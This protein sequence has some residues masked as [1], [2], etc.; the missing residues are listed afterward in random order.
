MCELMQEWADMSPEERREAFEQWFKDALEDMGLDPNDYDIKYEEPPMDPNR[1]G[2][3]DWSSDTFYF[4]PDNFE[5]E[6]SGPDDPEAMF[7]ANQAM[8]TGAHEARHAQQQDVYTDYGLN[9]GT[10]ADQGFR[11]QDAKDFGDDY[12]P[13]PDEE[14]PEPEEY[15]IDE[16]DMPPPS[17]PAGDFPLPPGDIAYA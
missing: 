3:Y 6:Y 13:D 2:A 5:G 15:A 7:D 11:E 17:S 1:A 12:V 8:E 4:N 14:C 9:E 16:G 10:A